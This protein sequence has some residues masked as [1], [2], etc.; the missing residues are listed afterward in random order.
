MVRIYAGNSTATVSLWSTR[1]KSAC[2]ASDRSH[3]FLNQK[4]WYQD[5]THHGLH[6][7][8]PAVQS[9]NAFNSR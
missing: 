1:T 5:R 6:K 3:N 4:P 2:Y 9:V 8:M 7:L